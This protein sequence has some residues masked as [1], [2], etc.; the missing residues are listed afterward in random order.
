MG[1]PGGGNPLM[2]KKLKEKE[3]KRKKEAEEQAAKEAAAKKAKEEAEA[4]DKD[5]EEDGKDKQEKNEES[6]EVDVEKFTRD[7]DTAIQRKDSAR[8]RTMV[9]GVNKIKVCCFSI[10]F[11]SFT[12]LW[13]GL[14]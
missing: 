2:A 9:E 13:A 6:D 7:L 8:V 1:M 11:L 3:E 5:E 12:P 14:G 4:P 10:F